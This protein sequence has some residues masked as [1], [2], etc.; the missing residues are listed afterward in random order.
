MPIYFFLQKQFF[1]FSVLLFSFILKMRQSTG[2]TFCTKYMEGMSLGPLL[3]D[4][5]V[6]MYNTSTLGLLEVQR[7]LSIILTF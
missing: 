3:V 4:K 6:H 5:Y 7:V 1:F 2:C